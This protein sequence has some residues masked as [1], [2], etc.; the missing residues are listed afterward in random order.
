MNVKARREGG[1]VKEHGRETTNLSGG[2]RSVARPAY[3]KDSR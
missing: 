1:F 2:S 3:F